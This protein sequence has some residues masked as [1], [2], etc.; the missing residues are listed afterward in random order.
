MRNDKNE[1][2]PVN[3]F[4]EMMEYFQNEKQRKDF[5]SGK[6]QKYSHPCN[7]DSNHS[8]LINSLQKQIRNKNKGLKNCFVSSEISA[9]NL[10]NE[11]QMCLSSC[12][13]FLSPKLLERSPKHRNTKALSPS[14]ASQMYVNEQK[15]F[16]SS[17]KFVDSPKF[18]DLTKT[19]TTINNQIAKILVSPKLRKI[20]QE[21]RVKM[22]LLN[23]VEEH[24]LP[25]KMTKNNKSLIFFKN[26]VIQIEKNLIKEEKAE[27]KNQPTLA[28][29]FN[30]GSTP[31]K[32]FIKRKNAKSTSTYVSSK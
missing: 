9:T 7:N 11:T 6:T 29:I 1:K 18:G 4:N 19:Q 24:K 32:F 13:G 16:G 14:F 27:M 17:S 21:Q 8:V 10:N 26:K 25:I 15:V 5:I 31:T 20:F 12:N 30:Q 28:D 22:P 3:D 2:L 23:G